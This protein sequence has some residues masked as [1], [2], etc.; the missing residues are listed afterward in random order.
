[1]T[2]IDPMQEP[3]WPLLMALAWVGTRSPAVV[4]QL[5]PQ[6]REKQGR[7][8]PT[9]I[10]LSV[11]LAHS[12]HAWLTQWEAGWWIKHQGPPDFGRFSEERATSLLW[13]EL[14]S[15]RVE[16]WACA[17]GNAPASIQPFEFDFLQHRDPDVL[18][19]A[20][21]A[22]ARYFNAAVDVPQLVNAFPALDLQPVMVQPPL[23][24]EP[25]PEAV[26]SLAPQAPHLTP[27][28]RVIAD[29]VAKEWPEGLPKFKTKKERNRKV[30]AVMK[31]LGFE[32][33]QPED[34]T[35]RRYFNRLEPTT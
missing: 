22:D 11:A 27:T 20:G 3:R 35:F 28:E 30:Y 2:T 1:M 25:E 26:P 8:A 15:G 6:L 34:V 5:W 7:D 13:R 4:R 12:A 32:D 21:E 19:Y 33:G 23:A 24:D 9:T 31:T 29:A 16:A 17:P 18:A 10:T 14:R